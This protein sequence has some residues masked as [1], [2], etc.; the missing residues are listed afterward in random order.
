MK[1]ISI[2]NKSLSIISVILF[3]IVIILFIA[4]LFADK[5]YSLYINICG[6]MSLSAA[7]NICWAVSQRRVEALEE[8]VQKLLD[9]TFN[10]P[11]ESLKEDEDKED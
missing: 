7:L 4:S 10:L 6:W 8:I 9:V 1:K 3:S 5:P 2:S 11:S